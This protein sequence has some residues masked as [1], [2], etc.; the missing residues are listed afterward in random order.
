MP[1]TIQD[2]FEQ[3]PR[4]FRS[5]Y[6]SATPGQRSRPYG[7]VITLPSLVMHTQCDVAH[8]R[9]IVASPLCLTHL[10]VCRRCLRL[11]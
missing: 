6:A 4:R 3:I 1:I 11:L 2:V 8:V 10:Q 5:K 7:C 9:L